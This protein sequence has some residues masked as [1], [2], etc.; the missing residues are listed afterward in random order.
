MEAEAWKNRYKPGFMPHG[1]LFRSEVG[2]S[3]CFADVVPQRVTLRKKPEGIWRMYLDGKRERRLTPFVEVEAVPF[4]EAMPREVMT[5]LNAKRVRRQVPLKMFTD[6]VFDALVDIIRNVWDSQRSHLVWHS[7]GYDS[8]LLSLAIRYL[9]REGG[10]GW[11]GDVL[12]VEVNGESEPFRDIMR[13][14]GWEDGQHAIYK[15]DELGSLD[16]HADAVK[17][18]DAWE[19]MNGVVA[20]PSTSWWGAVGHF[21][22]RGL[23]PEDDQM[24]CFTGMFSNQISLTADVFGLRAGMRRAYYCALMAL[25]MKGDFVHPYLNL[26]FIGT[27]YTHSVGQGDSSWSSYRK[28]MVEEIASE[29]DAALYVTIE[30]HSQSIYRYISEELLKQTIEDYEASWY[31]QH[32]MSVSQ[33]KPTRRLCY[34]AW[35]GHWVTASL[36]EHL[37]ER[38]HEI[39]R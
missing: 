19:R 27:E 31:G 9:Y 32:A 26:H 5:F 18:T 38:G 39:C 20:V 24:Q 4:D 1:R 30:E 15:E 36:C 14:E 25:G 37:L 3:P 6:I 8:R 13:I 16:Y 12:F 34:C 10:A 29:L 21:Q 17:F 35:W 23:V 28:A 7:S 33:L 2:V 11:L 22:Q